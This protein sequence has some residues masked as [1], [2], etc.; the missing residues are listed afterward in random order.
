MTSPTTSSPTTALDFL[1]IVRKSGLVTKSQLDQLFS[2]SAPFNPTQIAAALVRAE[3]LTQYQANQL[4]SGKFRGFF[5]GPYK[6]LRPVGKGGMGAVYLAEQTSVGRKVAIKVLPTDKAQDGLTLERFHREARAAAAL[7]HPNIVK[8][9]DFSQ[10][11]GVYFLVMEF[12]DGTDLQ[13]LIDKTGPLHYAQASQ[14]VAQVAAGLQH[15]HD[16]GFIHR[17]IKPANLILTKDGTVKILDMGLARPM[18][19]EGDNLTAQNGAGDIVGTVDFLPPEQAMSRPLDSRSDIYSLGA[20]FYALIA[21][22]PPF[23]GSTVQK[24]TQHQLKEPPQL[25][26]KLKG[27]VPQALSDIVAQMMAKLPSDRY[28]SASDVIEALSEWQPAAADVNTL[29]D[30]ATVTTLPRTAR[31]SGAQ[32]RAI[33]A[34][35]AAR[36]K[37]LK[38][39]IGAS[40]GLFLLFAGGVLALALGGKTADPGNKA[41]AGNNPLPEQTTPTNAPPKPTPPKIKPPGDVAGKPIAYRLDLSQQK[42]FTRIGIPALTGDSR[43]DV[44]FVE[45]DRTGSGD[46]PVGFERSS[47]FGDGQETE[48]AARMVDG[49]MAFGQRNLR[50]GKPF[51][52]SMFVSPIMSFSEDKTRLRLEYRADGGAGDVCYLRFKATEPAVQTWDIPGGNLGNTNGEWKTVDMEVPLL[53]AKA[54]HFEIHNAHGSPDV[55]IWLKAFEAGDLSTLPR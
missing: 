14:Y 50:L 38:L 32:L 41:G 34:N 52:A 37:R 19:G 35:D 36:R 31:L 9:Y 13:S 54:G 42:E 10:A 40:A 16:K 12:V 25:S 3:L 30:Q 28:Q 46:F 24:L 43:L 8:L 26:K 11:S 44:R 45:R 22:Q 6:L 51:G 53:G 29:N 47:P 5:L 1:E 15:A 21:G 2:N 17:D 20:T 7:D 49:V 39:L 55:W 33:Q 4:L 18:T 27:R 48:Y 23:A